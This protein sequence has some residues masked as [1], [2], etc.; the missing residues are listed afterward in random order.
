M[1]RL[2]MLGS[3]MTGCG[4]T[5]VVMARKV[6]FRRTGDMEVSAI[7]RM[8][9]VYRTA[10]DG[11][12]EVSAHDFHRASAAVVAGA[13]GE[14]PGRRRDDRGEQKRFGCGG[15]WEMRMGRL[16]EPGMRR[17]RKLVA[18]GSATLFDP[19]LLAAVAGGLT[20]R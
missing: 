7:R 9:I 3:G 12:V 1:R 19:D 13:G 10:I 16:G 14:K 17:R 11:T 5:M 2:M 6:A 20:T 8:P 15:S 4:G 18:L